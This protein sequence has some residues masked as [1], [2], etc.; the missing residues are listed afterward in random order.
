MKINFVGNKISFK[1][2]RMISKAVKLSLENLG[3]SSK[4]LEMS[5]AFISF[6]EMQELNN[7]TRGINKVTDVLSYPNFTISPYEKVDVE[8]IENY[9]GKKILLG[10][11]AICL[12]QARAQAKEFNHSMEDEVVKLVIHSTL[13]MMGFDHIED[14]DFEIMQKEEDKIAS[15]FYTNKKI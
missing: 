3:Q 10:D 12:E 2:K 14:D 6:D 7:R 1:L 11:M 5:I 4:E 8:N 15:K 9:N 13:H